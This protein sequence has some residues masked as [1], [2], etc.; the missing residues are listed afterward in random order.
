MKFHL[1]RRT[2]CDDRFLTWWIILYMY[3]DIPS[4]IV[5]STIY[6]YTIIHC[7][8][9]LRSILYIGTCIKDC[10]SGTTLKKSFDVSDVTHIIQRSMPPFGQV[11]THDRLHKQ[12]GF[13]HMFFLNEHVYPFGVQFERGYFCRSGIRCVLVVVVVMMEIGS[14]CHLHAIPAA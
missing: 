11:V 3:V 4:Y 1:C 12:I 8:V 5:R 7:I 14:V 9:P 6:Q 10:G 13:R 2:C